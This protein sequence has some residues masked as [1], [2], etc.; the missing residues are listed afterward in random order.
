MLPTRFR[1]AKALLMTKCHCR[2]E[3]IYNQLNKTKR[4]AQLTLRELLCTKNN[5]SF[6]IFDIRAL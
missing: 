3:D 4:P 6:V 5:K 2:Y 1:K